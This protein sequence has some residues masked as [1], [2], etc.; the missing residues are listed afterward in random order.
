MKLLRWG[1]PHRGEGDPTKGLR[2]SQ[3]GRARRSRTRATPEQ[4][5]CLDQGVGNHRQCQGVSSASGG[6]V[7]LPPVLAN[8]V[9]WPT[10]AI[11]KAHESRLQGP[12]PLLWILLILRTPLV[13][14]NKDCPAHKGAAGP[15]PVDRGGAGMD[16]Q[17]RQPSAVRETK[18]QDADISLYTGSSV[19]PS[20]SSSSRATISGTR[21]YRR[22]C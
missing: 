22:I 9:F 1:R 6:A 13:L 10:G 19:P 20:I 7:L 12:L 16:K 3:A 11:S 15:R 2:G 18:A 17:T 14:V 4:P 8:G 5:V 21:A